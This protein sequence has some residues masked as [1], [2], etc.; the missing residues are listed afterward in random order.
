MPAGHHL[1]GVLAP[2]LQVRRRTPVR[3]PMP[4]IRVLL[5]AAAVFA[6]AACEDEGPILSP[7]GGSGAPLYAALWH[8]HEANGDTLPAEISNRYIGITNE[9]VMLD[10]AQ[11][12]VR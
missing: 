8:A 4:R 2:D 6:V 1:S 7:G 10:S 9:I 12:L 11:L 5:I 3:I